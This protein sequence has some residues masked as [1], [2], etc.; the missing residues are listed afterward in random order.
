MVMVLRKTVQACDIYRNRSS[1]SPVLHQP[2]G[3]SFGSRFQNIIL[4]LVQIE[5]GLHA[6]FSRIYAIL[7][8]RLL[9]YIIMSFIIR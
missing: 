4:R 8:S 7:L 2:H 9:K 3:R 6:R 1:E 5:D